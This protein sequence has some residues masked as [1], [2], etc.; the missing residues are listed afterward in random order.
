MPPG[1]ALR[2]THG[3]KKTQTSISD[4]QTDAAPEELSAE[5]RIELRLEEIALYL[6]RI[7]R[8]D[9]YRM[10]SGYVHALIGFIPMAIFLG[11]MLYF[12]WYGEDLIKQLIQQTAQSAMEASTGGMDSFMKD[13]QNLLPG[14]RGGAEIQV[15]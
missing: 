8:R 3:V 9:H 15:R 14:G 7:D 12:Y 10:I 6:K 11:S 13:F 4:D 1:A 2:Y 5:Q